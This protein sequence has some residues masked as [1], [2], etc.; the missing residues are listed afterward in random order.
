MSDKGKPKKT[1]KDEL[2]TPW[3]F[4]LHNRPAIVL[5]AIVLCKILDQLVVF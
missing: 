3:N 1:L 4:A 5:Q 2:K